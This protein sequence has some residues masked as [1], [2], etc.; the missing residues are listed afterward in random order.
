MSKN[1][2][3]L[4]S[5]AFG[6]ALLGA[7]SPAL[8]GDGTNLYPMI[9]ADTQ[10]LVVFDVADARDSTLL[11]KGFQKML[12]MQ[13]DAKT[14]LA[15]IGIDPM[16]DIDTL[17]FAGGGVKSFDDMDTSKS[18]LIVIE[19]RLPKA[20]LATLPDAKK[21]TYKGVEIYS[22]DD[23]DAAFVG[24]RLFFTKKGAMKGQIDLAQGKAKGKSIA[25]SAK[26]KALKT[27]LA[28]TDTSADL[29][30]VV[31][32]P[33]ENKKDMSQ[34]GV[35]ANS[36]SAGVNFTA[37]MAIA[38]RVD[39]NSEDGA[40]K[41]VDMIQGQLGQ[42][43]G[44]MSQMGLGKAAK[45][46]RVSR[47]KAAIKMAITLTEA[48]INSLVAMA[49]MFGGGGQAAPAPGPTQ[50]KPAP[51][52]KATPAPGKVAPKASPG[53]APASGSMK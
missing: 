49:G 43:T 31:V 7:A 16:K 18:M 4:S 36:V 35:V 11:Q 23:T 29:W 45:S 37:D 10:I 25:G 14:K 34:A 40:Q 26:A 6:A 38:L 50:G 46:I 21:S 2:L 8:A 5:I 39:S 1:R 41:A 22:K 19:G 15:E 48:E 17:A 27:A 12:D 33:E 13:P 53:A 30:M 28:T 3:A 42:V 51:A 44:P 32:I 20:K 9:S 24:D 47:D 52:P